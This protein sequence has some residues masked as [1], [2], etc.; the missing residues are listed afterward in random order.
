MPITVKD[1]VS[2]RMDDYSPVL[3]TADVR[4]VSACVWSVS[5]T[6]TVQG[7]CSLNVDETLTRLR[8]DCQDQVRQSDRVGSSVGRLSESSRL[9]AYDR[10]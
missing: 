8:A 6:R 10:H 7:M 3:Q 9:S 4:C 2:A 1:M 5:R